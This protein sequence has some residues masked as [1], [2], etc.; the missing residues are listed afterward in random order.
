MGCVVEEVASALSSL[1]PAFMDLVDVVLDGSDSSS[2]SD[3]GVV[4]VDAQEERMN[5]P[6]CAANCF[7][8]MRHCMSSV[9]V[10]HFFTGFDVNPQWYVIDKSTGCPVA[11]TRCLG[12]DSLKTT[13]MVK[14]HSSNCKLHMRTLGDL[15]HCDAESLK[16]SISG[17]AL[18]ADEHLAAAREVLSFWRALPR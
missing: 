17:T 18:S 8:T 4:P 15:Q 14:G 12:G 10:L 3:D 16:W 1:D 11:K 6:P 7:Y 9:D 5:M 13:C 2:S